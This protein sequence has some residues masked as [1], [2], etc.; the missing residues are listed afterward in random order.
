MNEPRVES[1]RRRIEPSRPLRTPRAFSARRR[2]GATTA[3]RQRSLA[4]AAVILFLVLSG[5]LVWMVSGPRGTTAAAMVPDAPLELVSLSH[6]RQN[7]KL[8]VSGLVRNPVAGKPVER[9]SAVVLLFDRTGTFVASSRAH[10]DFLTLGTGDETP[11]VVSLDAPPTVARYRLSF[12]T[13]EGVVPHIDKRSASTAPADSRHSTRQ[14][15]VQ[16]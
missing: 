14:L 1:D 13:D 16:S 2:A 9:L 10:V 3:A 8:A 5:G 4:L 7:D 12:R 6:T 15:R 11:F